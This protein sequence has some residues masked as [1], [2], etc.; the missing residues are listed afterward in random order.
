M[1]P[2]LV[3]R[4]C[5]KDENK[6]FIEG[7]DLEEDVMDAFGFEKRNLEHEEGKGIKWLYR[8]LIRGVYYKL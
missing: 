6:R 7:G 2:S 1:S 3:N 8:Y 4:G 5:S